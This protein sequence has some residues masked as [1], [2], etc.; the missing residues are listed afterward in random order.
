M[1]RRRGEYDKVL[2]KVSGEAQRGDLASAT[3]QG[4]QVS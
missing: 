4:K 3:L 1:E 2:G